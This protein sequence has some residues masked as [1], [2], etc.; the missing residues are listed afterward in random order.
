MNYQVH[1]KP[2][3]RHVDGIPMFLRK[4]PSNVPKRLLSVVPV[5]TFR[6][7]SKGR[8]YRAMSS[9]DTGQLQVAPKGLFGVAPSATLGQPYLALRTNTC[10]MLV[11]EQ[12]W[13][14]PNSVPNP[15]AQS[16]KMDWGAEPQPTMFAEA[17]LTTMVV[18]AWSPPQM[19]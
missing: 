5:I 16:Y 6:Y 3:W 13:L 7:V 1:L 18:G 12:A 10:T 19:S 17:S 14:A 15:F 4:T 9:A 8:K 11:L 2:L